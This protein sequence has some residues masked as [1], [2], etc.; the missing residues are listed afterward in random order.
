MA[1]TATDLINAREVEAVLEERT[2]AM[3]QF[4]RAFRDDDATD[5]SANTKTFPVPSDTLED[6][7]TEVAE[8][9]DYP[10]SA[11]E[12][13][14]VDAEYTKDGFEVAISDEAADDSVIDILLDI[15]EEMA[16][17]AEAHLDHQAFAVLDT[18]NNDVTIGDG[19]DDLNF[20]SIVDAYT[21]MSDQRFNPENFEIYTSTYGF[22]SLA[23]DDTLNRATERGDDLA[24]AG[25]LGEVFGTDIAMT[26]TGAL[27][28]NEAILVDT[29]MYGYESTRWEREVTEYREERK[30]RDVFKVRVRNDFVAT[31]PD[32]ALFIEGG[33]AE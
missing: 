1:I 23:K 19:A 24:R 20:E 14:G 7:M 2:R 11:L 26:N 30:D 9:A 5:I 33:V 28:P 17:A 13:D 21:E 4:R 3:Y 22:G 6:D 18:Y 32:A 29:S 15:T 31:N 12:H 16:N 25:M 27:G 8:E 10:R